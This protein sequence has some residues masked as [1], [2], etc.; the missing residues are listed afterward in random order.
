MSV[1]APNYQD[2]VVFE[3]TLFNMPISDPDWNWPKAWDKIPMSQLIFWW[4][5]QQYPDISWILPDIISKTKGFDESIW[6][7]PIRLQWLIN[8]LVKWLQSFNNRERNHIDFYNFTD[9]IQNSLYWYLSDFPEILEINGEPRNCTVEHLKK[10]C[11]KLQAKKR[12]EEIWNECTEKLFEILKQDITCLRDCKASIY[13]YLLRRYTDG[14]NPKDEEMRAL[15]VSEP[16]IIKILAFWSFAQILSL[17]TPEATLLWENWNYTLH[18]L[19]TIEHLEQQTEFTGICIWESKHYFA[20]IHSWEVRIF[21][22]HDSTSGIKYTI[23]YNVR[24]SQVIQWEGHSWNREVPHE[25]YPEIIT[26]ME[27]SWIPVN[28]ILEEYRNKI[29]MDVILWKKKWK[30][31]FD[32]YILSFHRIDLPGEIEDIYASCHE[33]EKVC[34][35]KITLKENDTY[36]NLVEIFDWEWTTIDATNFPQEEKNKITNVKW[37]LI[38]TSEDTYFPNMI[39]LGQ[40]GIWNSFWRWNV[41]LPKVKEIQ[42]GIDC[43]NIISLHLDNLETVYWGVNLRQCAYPKLPSLK[44]IYW[45]LL[46][47][48]LARIR[49][50]S[51]EFI[52]EQ[53]VFSWNFFEAPNLHT[54]KYIY[55]TDEVSWNI[56]QL[57]EIQVFHMKKWSTIKLPKN[58][59]FEIIWT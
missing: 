14:W 54:A 30:D 8:C 38:D 17:L 41:R 20:K 53:I 50:P 1:L 37:R 46:C 51:F 4:W 57:E 55:F 24:D 59:K 26:I 45:D 15:W 32:T 16:M 47:D 39:S 6:N 11:E 52:S 48:S 28:W 44:S 58:R 3:D 31:T 34:S 22:F 7:N 40:A 10:I 5:S 43:R 23:E 27:N 13:N 56:E 33:M 21:S 42:W 18:E 29:W 9:F 25:L 12:R 2:Q 19:V 49:L 36:E 35:G